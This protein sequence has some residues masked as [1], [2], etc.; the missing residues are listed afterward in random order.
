MKQQLSQA[1]KRTGDILVWKPSRAMS[2]PPSPLHVI[3]ALLLASVLL[4]VFAV[5]SARAAELVP[6][7]PR[8]FND[9]FGYSVSISGDTVY[10]GAPLDDDLG[11]NS[12]TVAVYRNIS[13]ATGIVTESV[14]L[15]SN[16]EIEN[17]NFGFAVSVSGDNA[18]V[19]ALQGDY[20]Q[21]S[22]FAIFNI[23][24]A[25]PSQLKLAPSST[26]F[27]RRWLGASAS[28]SGNSALVGTYS[29]Y[30]FKTGEAYLYR[31][32]DS[33]VVETRLTSSDGYDYRGRYGESVALAGDIALVGSPIVVSGGF[34]SGA[35][36]MYRNLDFATPVQT[37]ISPFDPGAAGYFGGS[38]SLSGTTALVG[39]KGQGGGAAYVIRNLDSTQVQTKLMPSDLSIFDDFGTAVSLSGNT[40][41]VGASSALTTAAGR[42]GAAYLFLN[43]NSGGANV[44]V[45]EDLKIFASTGVSSDKFGASVSIDGDNFVIGAYSRNDSGSAFTGSVSSMTTMDT[46]NTTRAIDALSFVSKRDWIIGQTTDGNIVQLTSGDAASVIAPGKAVYIGQA[47]GS[48]GNKLI[49]S[50]SLKANEINIGSTSGNEGNALQ[51]DS[52]A[53]FGP[54]ILRLADDNFL[55]I[56]GNYTNS[57]ALLAYLG[58]STLQ[59]WDSDLANWIS[60]T[61]ENVS[62]LISANFTS[63]YTMIQVGVVPEP[64]TVA[65][66]V[67]GGG[68]ALLTL[69]RRKNIC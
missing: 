56:Q 59:V 12:G 50:G 9:W 32:I 33:T 15:Y 2:V 66:M 13:T 63:G 42:P 35:V 1:S 45:T 47:V 43:A 31:N 65:M 3:R 55:S 57:L 52:T 6:S 67:L 68:A 22:T 34:P 58:A 30:S 7:G 40:A 51:L 49:I 46:G 21:G 26:P 16:G 23:N 24:S 39:A 29:E 64:S 60:I 54:I 10:V 18:F 41:L 37:K 8:E 17:D 62:D 4:P 44:T 38:V 61:G 53:V 48:D 69:R 28:L 27:V 5:P 25:N 19:T 11:M 36:Y 20:K 14:K